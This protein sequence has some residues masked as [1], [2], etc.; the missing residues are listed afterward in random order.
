MSVFKKLMS[1]SA[2]G[3]YYIGFFD[4]TVLTVS[5]ATG[6]AFLSS[7][8]DKV[9][10]AIDEWG[11]KENVLA[12][13][14]DYSQGDIDWVRLIDRAYNQ[15]GLTGTLDT[16]DNLYLSMSG[17]TVF[18]RSFYKLSSSGTTLTQQAYSTIFVDP[19]R[20]LADGSALY[21]TSVNSAGGALTISFPLT[22]GSTN[23]NN[24]E[25]YTGNTQFPNGVA[26]DASNFYIFGR[27]GALSTRTW[28]AT[29][30]TKST[31]SFTSKILEATGFTLEQGAN[32]RGSLFLDSGSKLCALGLA[33][34]DAGTTNDLF[35][36]RMDTALTTVDFAKTVVD[37]QA[38]IIAGQ[39]TVGNYYIIMRTASG[40]P[41]NGFYVIK[42]NS[43]GVHQQ[44]WLVTSTDWSLPPNLDTAFVTSLDEMGVCFNTGTGGKVH[45]AKLPCD[46]ASVEG[47][48][49]NLT[50]ASSSALTHS[51]ETVTI[52]VFSQ[53]SDTA[54]NPSP[55]A[56]TPSVTTP[57]TV[58]FTS[59]LI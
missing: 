30:V 26:Q 23:W 43:S 54:S 31:G 9:Y 49:G 35:F 45:F 25:N 57:S 21:F 51:T 7:G 48:Y 47:V 50:I 38:G 29:S 4:D 22:F 36:I 56:L 46:L 18:N 59:Q 32:V 42:Y 27:N 5:T 15:S 8:E 41:D 6:E 3:E 52:S 55:S 37:G 11:A 33:S 58:T 10:F 19:Q 1:V 53:T 17:P 39:D 44:D 20:I 13:R 34:S 16:S 28:Y 12:L 2:V 40:A 24:R 14:L